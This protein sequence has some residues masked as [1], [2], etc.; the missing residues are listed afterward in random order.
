[1][2]LRTKISEMNVFIISSTKS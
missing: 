1:M 2:M